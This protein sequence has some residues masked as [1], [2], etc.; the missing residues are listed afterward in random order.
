LEVVVSIRTSIHLRATG[1]LAKPLFDLVG[2]KPQRPTKSAVGDFVLCR[3][4][5]DGVDGVVTTLC[6]VFR[7][8]EFAHK[9][10]GKVSTRAKSR[11]SAQQAATAWKTD[12]V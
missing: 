9:T 3:E 1:N 7:S 2:I 4:A 8:D 11:H 10:L 12:D 5:A 6:H